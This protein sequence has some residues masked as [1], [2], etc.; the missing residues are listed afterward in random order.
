M[1]FEQR[2]P[3]SHLS[4]FLVIII[5]MLIFLN[6]YHQVVYDFNKIRI[7]QR[8]HYIFS[9]DHDIVNSGVTLQNYIPLPEVLWMIL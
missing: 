4:I 6:F 1:L 9:V 7:Y 2:I 8:S 5:Q 3:V